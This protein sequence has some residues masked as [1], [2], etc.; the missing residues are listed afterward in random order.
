MVDPATTPNHAAH[1]GQT[2]HFCS[3]GCRTKF[4]AHPETYLDAAPREAMQ[5]PKDAIYTCPMHPQ[6]EQV[7]PGTCPICGMALEPKDVAVVE[8]P[9]E[10]YLDMRRRFVVSAVLTVPLV[11]VAM[12]R[13]FFFPE[14]NPIISMQWL[15]W[16]ELV[17]AT[18]VIL[19]GGWPFFVRGWASIRTWHLNMFTGS[20]AQIA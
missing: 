10:E 3:A 12:G 19:W 5:G 18:P 13:Q 20:V 16:F 17:L 7:G 4:V 15:G 6:I 14:A 11:V 8:G 9:S 2:Y 1:A